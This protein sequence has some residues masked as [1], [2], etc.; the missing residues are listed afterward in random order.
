MERTASDGA[1]GAESAGGAEVLPPAATRAT[2]APTPGS[3]GTAPRRRRLGAAPCHAGAPPPPRSSPA[4]VRGLPV[5]WIR[6]NGGAPVVVSSEAGAPAAGRRHG[7]L[8]AAGEAHAVT[9]ARSTGRL[10]SSC[11]TPA[12]FLDSVPWQIEVT[13]FLVPLVTAL[14][15]VEALAALMRDQLVRLRGRLQIT[16][17]GPVR[18]H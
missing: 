12:A 2:S 5:C 13:R 4:P 3:S 14:T 7:H 9:P 10:S 8:A 1:R 17:R 6:T 15:A 11:S 18:H 16:C